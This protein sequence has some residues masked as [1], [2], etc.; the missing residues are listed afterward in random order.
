MT[1]ADW[2]VDAQKSKASPTVQMK[3]DRPWTFPCTFMDRPESK[4]DPFGRTRVVTWYLCALACLLSGCAA[5]VSN[6]A[7]NGAGSPRGKEARLPDRTLGYGGD[8][9]TP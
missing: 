9:G 8:F 6:M 4:S 7:G 5:V 2:P 1:E 3:E